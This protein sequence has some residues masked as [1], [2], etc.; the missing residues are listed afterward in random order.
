MNLTRLR[1]G[2][3]LAFIGAV[4]LAVLTFLP[5]YR[6]QAGNLTAWDNFGVV[7][8]LIVIAV[9]V[10]LTLTAATVTE[11][12][13]ALP[14]ASAVWTTLVAFMAAVAILVALLDKPDHAVSLRA[15]SWLSLVAALA[16]LA[17]GWQS[18]RDER[19]ERY[20]A[21]EPEPRRPRL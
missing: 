13:P 11:R 20:A 9:L 21:A 10:A 8:V 2:E 7:D 14:I 19:T 6:G 5:W 17:G 1:L 16:I 4:A 12:G 18:M 3:L 15:A